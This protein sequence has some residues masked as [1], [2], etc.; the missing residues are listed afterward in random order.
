MRIKVL[1]FAGL[2]E[3]LGVNSVDVDLVGVTSTVSSLRTT[4]IARGEPWAQAL[5]MGKSLRAAVDHSMVSEETVIREG[6]EVAF[7]PP[8]TGG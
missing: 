7:F 4:L 3:S 6:S 2:R 5:A 1:F 8:V